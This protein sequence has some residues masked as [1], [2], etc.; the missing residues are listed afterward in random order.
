M[1]EVTESNRESYFFNAE[2]GSGADESGWNHNPVAVIPK[3]DR[4][5][6]MPKDQKPR[7]QTG[8]GERNWNAN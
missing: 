6:Q 7:G 1:S 5:S 8:V 3:N 4:K 2:Q